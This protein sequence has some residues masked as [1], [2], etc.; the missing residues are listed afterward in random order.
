[1]RA[2]LPASAPGEQLVAWEPMTA[3]THAL[4]SGDG[5][6]HVVPRD[7][8]SASFSVSYGPLG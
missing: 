6:R 1:M 8:F 2:I 5:L 4:G 3:P 7:T